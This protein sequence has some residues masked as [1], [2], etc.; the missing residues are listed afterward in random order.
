[1]SSQPDSHKSLRLQTT[2]AVKG[3]LAAVASLKEL[4]SLRSGSASRLNNP[5]ALP[6]P[7]ARQFLWTKMLLRFALQPLKMYGTRGCI[8]GAHL[9]GNLFAQRHASYESCC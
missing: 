9:A 2:C 4:A 5:A 6:I 1:M 8:L 3:K 7:A